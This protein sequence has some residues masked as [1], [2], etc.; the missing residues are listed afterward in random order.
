[1]YSSPGTIIISEFNNGIFV[2]NLTCNETDCTHKVY[3]FVTM[4]NAGIL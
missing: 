1:M 2:M 4:K 3:S